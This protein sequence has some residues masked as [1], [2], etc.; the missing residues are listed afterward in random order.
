VEAEDRIVYLWV[1]QV[2]LVVVEQV[3]EELQPQIQPKELTQQAEV[4]VDKV[5]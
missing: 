2:V 5:H 3:V 4:V 1:E